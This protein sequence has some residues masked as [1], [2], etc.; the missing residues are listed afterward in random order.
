MNP[1]HA[2]I[3]T[4]LLS[5]TTAM[6]MT[7]IS[8]DTGA[9]EPC[10][11]LGECKVLVEI[12]SSDGD[13]GFHFLA[14]GDDLESLRLLAPTTSD[15]PSE[16]IFQYAVSGRLREQTITET[17]AES[18]E[19]LCWA[20]PEADPDEEIVTLE[21]FIERWTP[22]NYI[23]D[24]RN[25]DNEPVRGSTMLNHALP[26]APQEI[27]FEDGMVS[28]TRG[29]DLGNC[30]S[31]AELDDLVAQGLLPIHPQD[32]AVAAWE[33]VVEP[34][35]EDGDR[36][37]NLV[38]SIRVTGKIPPMEVTVPE[39]YLDSLPADTPVKIEVGAIGFRDN[40]TFT[41]RDGFCVNEEEGCED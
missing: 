8:V 38:Y 30:A 2:K 36:V 22:G 35:V 7:G 23:F 20:D 28:W 11:D 15:A 14:D 34:D 18:A 19:P 24:G 17:F 10:V 41:E 26:A 27:E 5:I 21:E 9:R 4:T 12:N 37:G 16:T 1:S 40:A 39:D 32:V 6:F 31:N 25:S 13:I 33:I 29:D 3:P